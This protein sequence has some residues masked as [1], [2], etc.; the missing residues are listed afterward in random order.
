MAIV[1]KSE[2]L[3]KVEESKH[4]IRGAKQ[5]DV[6][7]VDTQEIG[8]VLGR[9]AELESLN[10]QKATTLEFSRESFASNTQIP[11]AFRMS[12]QIALK[13]FPVEEIS[14]IP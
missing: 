6:P 13:T 4:V 11:G 14:T 5:N 9:M 7:N 1:Q 8:H 10:R 2:L 3:S 12:K